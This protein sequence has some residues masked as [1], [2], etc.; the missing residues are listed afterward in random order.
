M[1]IT[2]SCQSCQTIL[3]N[4]IDKIQHQTCLMFSK[5]ENV[6]FEQSSRIGLP[7][8]LMKC[9]SCNSIIGRVQ[10]NP[11]AYIPDKKAITSQKSFESI[12]KS[13]DIVDETNQIQK[14]DTIVEETKQIPSTTT[15]QSNK[16]VSTLKTIIHV[17]LNNLQF[18]LLLFSN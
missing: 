9:I 10:Q 12:D 18:G 3:F 14:D 17:G 2:Y 13:N 1:D 4:E 5:C 6:S 11:I 15:K 7:V 16:F 8:V